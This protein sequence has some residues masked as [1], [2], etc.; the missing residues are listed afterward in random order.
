M[1]ILSL[2]LV[3]DL[4]SRSELINSEKL[5]ANHVDPTI[6]RLEKPLI[7]YYDISGMMI[8]RLLFREPNTGNPN[9]GYLREENPSMKFPISSDS[10][11]TDTF[12]TFFNI[13]EFQGEKGKQIDLMVRSFNTV[14]ASTGIFIPYFLIFDSSGKILA[15]Q[16][17]VATVD[18]GLKNPEGLMVWL[19]ELVLPETQSYYII[20]FSDNTL[21]GTQE[22]RFRL[23]IE[24]TH[25][26]LAYKKEGW[27]QYNRFPG[28]IDL[29]I[30]RMMEKDRINVYK[31]V[32]KLGLY[33][34]SSM[35]KYEL[36][37]WY[38]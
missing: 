35:G 21:F 10:V 28:A 1:K 38:Y 23:G 8:N 12:D 25:I 6:G 32:G 2:F 13:W 16:E 22:H 24:R 3:Q 4:G 26:E 15:R 18:A 7:W 19:D 17:H 31:I 11:E 34:G 14:S 5:Q 30:S 37:L 36:M 27:I 29:L 20:V 33:L 9:I